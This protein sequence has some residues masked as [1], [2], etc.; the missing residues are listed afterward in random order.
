MFMKNAHQ[1]TDVQIEFVK[2]GVDQGDL[3]SG[4]LE[5]W[6]FN[7]ENI[8]GLSDGYDVSSWYFYPNLSS[9]DIEKLVD[10]DIPVLSNEYGDWVWRFDYGCSIY[11]CF[12]PSMLEALFGT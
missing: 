11:Q 2:R 8:Q 4:A 3:V 5:Y 1:Y 12:Y 10:A 9:K 6:F 7:W